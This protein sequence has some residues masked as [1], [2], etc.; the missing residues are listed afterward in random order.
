MTERLARID[1]LPTEQ[2]GRAAPPLGPRYS[3]SV[4]FEDWAPGPEGANWSLV[5]EMIDRSV[6]SMTWT[7]NVHF[8][9]E[10]APS[11]SLKA[12]TRFE[13]YEGK[14]CVARGTILQAVLGTSAVGQP[15][16][17]PH[18]VG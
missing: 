1:W 5:V 15:V 14:K 13:W 7:A 6:D 8:L 3:T 11:E 9:F 12:G 4:R 10:E 17:V 18:Q 16:V 2:G